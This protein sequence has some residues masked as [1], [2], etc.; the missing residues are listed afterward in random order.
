MVEV[1]RCNGM[2]QRRCGVAGPIRWH[3]ASSNMGAGLQS[4]NG[5]ATAM[6]PG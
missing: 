5:G 1:M 3:D 4:K 2:M 6:P